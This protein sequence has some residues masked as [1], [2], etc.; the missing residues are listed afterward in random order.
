MT[1]AKIGAGQLQATLIAQ[2]N[3][4]RP[5]NSLSSVRITAIGNAAVT[6][7]GSPVAAGQT[8]TLPAGSTQA[9]LL[10]DRRGP[11]QNPGL[12]S[13][14]AFVVTDACGEWKSFVGGGPS[15]F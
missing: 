13:T 11:P 6:L 10:L 15:A 12:A 2:T 7:N 5:T 1:T 14:V 8:I 4:L 3:A 9:T